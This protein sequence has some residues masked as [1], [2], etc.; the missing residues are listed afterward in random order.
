MAASYLN[1]QWP[2]HA[3]TYQDG[4]SVDPAVAADLGQLQVAYKQTWGKRLGTKRS[5]MPLGK[6]GDIT[7]AT[8]YGARYSAEQ[9]SNYFDE[10]EDSPHGYGR[11]VDFDVIPGS[12]QDEWLQQQAPA[13]N[14]IPNTTPEQGH[15]VHH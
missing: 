9:G 13:Y 14:W 5:Y 3:L 11:A 8:L 10:P 15:Y 4:A 2:A 12:T 7:P 1:G 6:P